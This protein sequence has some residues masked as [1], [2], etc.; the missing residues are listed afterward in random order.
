MSPAEG[1]V[2]VV[3]STNV[4]RTVQVPRLPRPGETALGDALVVS[5]GG[6]G[7]NAAAAAARARANVVFVSAVGADADGE[8]ALATLRAEGVEPAAV[9]IREHAPTGAA[10][11]VTDAEGA[12]LIAVAPGANATVDPEHVT[13]SLAGISGADVVLVSAEI[14]EAAV[15]AAVHAGAER[16]AATVLDPAPARPSLLE[17][18]RIGAI[19]T[20]NESEALELTGC[21]DVE[22]AARALSE[23]TGRAAVIT[24]GAAGCL[25]ADGGAVTRVAAAP[26]DAIVDTVGAGD[27]FAGGLAAALARGDALEIAVAAALRAAAASLGHAGARPAVG[28]GAVTTDST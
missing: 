14:P 25:M 17:A 11:I 18:A 20:P 24:L 22:E 3:G 15:A 5:P 21:A 7:A 26:V 9:A 4:D 16:A 19:L 13:R 6:K 28:Y 2:F 1:R 27:A 8:H 23:L 10:L 12:N